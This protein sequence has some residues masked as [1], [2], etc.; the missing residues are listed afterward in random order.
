MTG[1]LRR[2]LK[3]L[4][5]AEKELGGD[6]PMVDEMRSMIRAS[7]LSFKRICQFIEKGKKN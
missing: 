5:K 3:L 4:E 6:D 1:Q 2:S 7:E